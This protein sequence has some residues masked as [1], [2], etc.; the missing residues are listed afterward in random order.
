[1]KSHI[2][3][4][5]IVLSLTGCN[6][7]PDN[8]LLLLNNSTIYEKNIAFKKNDIEAVESRIEI[9]GG[10]KYIVEEKALYDSVGVFK[11]YTAG[12]EGF[13]IHSR[14]DDKESKSIERMKFYNK[15]LI[16]RKH[17]YILDG[18]DTIKS[19]KVLLKDKVI[20]TPANKNDRVYIYKFK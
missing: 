1:M 15:I 5:L 17:N 7:K 6:S 4:I 10:T 12:S 14:N 20:I 13:I 19:F 9:V 16:N 2:Y 3:L 11:L 18:N 8:S